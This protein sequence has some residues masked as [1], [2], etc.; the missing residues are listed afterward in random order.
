MNLFLL[1]DDRFN[2]APAR[3]G[4]TGLTLLGIDVVR[5]LLAEELL[6][7]LRG[8]QLLHFLV[9]V[10]RSPQ[11]FVR[12]HLDVG[13]LPGKFLQPGIEVFLGDSFL[14]AEWTDFLDRLDEG[15][16]AV[17]IK[18]R[19]RARHEV[20]PQALGIHSDAL[21]KLLRQGHH[22]LRMVIAVRDIVALPEVASADEHPVAT[23]HE[24]TKY[25]G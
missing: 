2:G 7:L 24:G 16:D 25:M 10:H 13:D 19:F 6:D 8:E 21:Q 22:V 15:V 9:A 5:Q 14:D 12:H 11:L 18:V 4:H 1:A 20:Q 3:T 17:R 23:V